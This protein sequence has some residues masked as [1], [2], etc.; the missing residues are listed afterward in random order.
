MIKDKYFRALFVIAIVVILAIFAGCNNGSIY[1]ES[2]GQGGYSIVIIDSC[3]Y[4]TTGMGQSRT[5]THKG[6]C[7]FCKG[8]K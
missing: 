2:K 3:E 1:N 6:N 5:L 4:I 7:K 8:R